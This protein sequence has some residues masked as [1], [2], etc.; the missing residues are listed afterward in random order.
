VSKDR[1]EFGALSVLEEGSTS[2]V[3]SVR[4]TGNGLLK[5]A[6]LN[7]AIGGEAVFSSDA[8]ALL[9]L[10][11]DQAQQIRVVFSPMGS[12]DYEAILFPNGQA[13]IQ[14]SGKGLAPSL[15]TV[16]ESLSFEN[17]PIGCSSQQILQ[18]QNIG[19][20]DLELQAV[21]ITG[22]SAFRV[23]VDAP[24]V[25][26]PETSTE[27]I[28]VFAPASGNLHNS[29][30]QI[31]SNDPET[32]VQVLPLSAVGFEGESVS[33]QFSYA[34]Y[35]RADLLFVINEKASVISHLTGNQSAIENFLMDLS[36][37]DWRV[38]IT[39]IGASCHLMSTAWVDGDTDM[40]QAASALSSAFNQSGTGGQK[41]FEKALSLLERTD[42]G[43]C[44]EGFLR[45][46]A[47]LQF[48]FVS[49]LT[50]TSSGS[51]TENLNDMEAQLESWQSL[52]VSSF[53]GTGSN[54]CIHTPRL[55]SAANATQGVHV[56]LCT[57]DLSDFLDELASRALQERDTT[58]ALDLAEIP[59]LSTLTARANGTVLS[60]WQYLSTSNQLIVDG[61]LEELV[62]G[63]EIFVD[64][65]S[66]VACE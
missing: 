33:Q 24:I 49:D 8:P 40:T 50:E 59:V 26:A 64:Y 57:A 7:K 38:A 48:A 14:L 65:L 19:E 39:N 45:E 54:G 28:L 29:V 44:M 10:E 16:P 35:G 27:A 62:E 55:A 42:E 2:M 9:E 23:D 30:L 46:N 53:S 61:Q 4:N 60:A 31:Q 63:D 32:P 47:L 25:L 13:T 36:G 43:D 51:V 56:D 34:P 41:L 37:L 11:P 21:E 66:A 17:K 22:S 58:V 6:G 5:V 1:L 20:E 15:G 12:K 3:F 52:S 18:I